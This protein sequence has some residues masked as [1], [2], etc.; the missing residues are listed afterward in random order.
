MKKQKWREVKKS[1]NRYLTTLFIPKHVKTA[2]I[3]TTNPETPRG[4]TVCQSPVIGRRKVPPCSATSG[5]RPNMSNRGP[6]Y[7]SHQIMCCQVNM[8][9]K[10][11][12][13]KGTLI[14]NSKN[15]ELKQYID[16]RIPSIH[17]CKAKKCKRGSLRKLNQVCWLTVSRKTISGS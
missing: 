11:V 2:L 9:H 1:E 10:D 3:M 17:D 15:M 5:K 16:L 7:H 4:S 12:E 14:Q 13:Y 8:H 6:C